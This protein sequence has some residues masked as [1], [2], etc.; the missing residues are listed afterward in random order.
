MSS[1]RRIS[2]E[3]RLQAHWDTLLEIVEQIEKDAGPTHPAIKLLL[4][5]RRT[6]DSAMETL[7]D[8]PLEI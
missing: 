6:I 3:D 1:K 2:V 5:A 7:I 8:Q 4:E